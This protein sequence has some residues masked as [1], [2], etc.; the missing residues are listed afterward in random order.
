MKDDL[1][2]PSLSLWCVPVCT[3]PPNKQRALSDARPTVRTCRL[4]MSAVLC[5]FGCLPG[6]IVLSADHALYVLCVWCMDRTL[7]DEG[8]FMIILRYEINGRVKEWM[9]S[10]DLLPHDKKT[11]CSR[12]AWMQECST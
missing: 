9:Y 11:R 4:R 6:P 2:R 5:P 3:H 8:L 1:S 7:F 12:Y 10:G